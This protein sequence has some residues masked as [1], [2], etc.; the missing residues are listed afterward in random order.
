MGVTKPPLAH[1]E[2]ED[3]EEEKARAEG[4]LRRV[5]KRREAYRVSVL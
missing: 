1:D 4:G 5:L 3:M 2:V